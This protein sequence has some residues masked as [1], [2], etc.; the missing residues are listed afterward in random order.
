MNWPRV[1]EL[2]ARGLRVWAPEGLHRHGIRKTDV[3]PG[4]GGLIVFENA[5]R[6]LYGVHWDCGAITAHRVEEFAKHLI[7]IGHCQSLEDYLDLA[8]G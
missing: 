1:G 2:P 6:D 7:C 4:T 5:E 8:N 3:A